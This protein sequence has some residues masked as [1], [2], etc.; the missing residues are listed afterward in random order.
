MS[1]TDDELLSPLVFNE[2]HEDSPHP[3]VVEPKPD[4]PS[5][6]QQPP[7]LQQHQDSVPPLEVE[8]TGD[9]ESALNEFLRSIENPEAPS[10]REEVQ[11]PAQIPSEGLSLDTMDSLRK[12]LTRFQSE[13]PPDEEINPS[14]NTESIQQTPVPI[15]PASADVGDE[16]GDDFLVQLRESLANAHPVEESTETPSIGSMDEGQIPSS[17]AR[18]QGVPDYSELFRPEETPTTSGPSQS[19]PVAETYSGILHIILSPDADKATI[20]FFWDVIDTVAGA[21]TVIAQTPLPDGS[22][23]ELTLDLGNDVLGLEQL[24]R[25]IPGADIVALGQDRLRIRLTPIRD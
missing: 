19:L 22:G 10:T 25:R 9:L 15:E 21:G 4:M 14:Q 13:R 23:H 12:E 8:P 20:S 16:F 2:A 1:S 18:P 7:T 11:E 3:E 17:P 6:Q 24:K 5:F